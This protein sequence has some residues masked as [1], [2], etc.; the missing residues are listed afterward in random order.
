MKLRLLTAT[1]HQVLACPQDELLGLGLSR[2]KAKSFHGLA[3]AVTDGVIDFAALDDLDD[4][5]AHK[6]L[7][8]LPGIGPWTA[9]IYLLSVM[10]RADA[11][12]WGDV[13]LQAAAQDLFHTAARP[14]KKADVGAGRGF[15]AL[16][17]CG[18][19]AALGALPGHEA[20]VAGLKFIV[21]QPLHRAVTHYIVGDR[22]VHRMET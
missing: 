1:A 6:A 16:S 21:F 3:Q 18:G 8:A 4:V 20:N 7:V 19:T 10:L 14:D 22:V 2:A 15:P 17:G 5:I 12:P 11:W 13:A 9:D